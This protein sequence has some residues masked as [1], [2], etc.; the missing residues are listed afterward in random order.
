MHK[1][2]KLFNVIIF[3]LVLS[4]LIL[5]GGCG[6]TESKITGLVTQEPIGVDSVS[7]A[8]LRKNVI[9]LKREN[10]EMSEKLNPQ[11]QSLSR[12][13]D[14]ESLV[15]FKKKKP[16]NVPAMTKKDFMDFDKADELVRFLK[17]Y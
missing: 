5:L 2:I 12:L 7:L 15:I 10:K 17:E 9:V 16:K 8:N 1:K 3:L 11:M 13:L 14:A 6:K 4:F